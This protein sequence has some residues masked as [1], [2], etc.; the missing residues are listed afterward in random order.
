MKKINLF[1]LLTFISLICKAPDI[2]MFFIL[3]HNPLNPY[4]G[5]W[6]AICEHES[7]NDPMAY[8]R[9]ENAVGIVQIRP[10]LLKQYNIETRNNFQIQEMYDIKKSK[11][12]FMH[13]AK[14]NKTNE[15]I[16]RCWNGGPRG[17]SK[18]ITQS[19]YAEVKSIININQNGNRKTN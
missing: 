19:Y 2:K 8:N 3:T 16:A 9:K 5:I 15:K 13:F 17:M 1:I 11:Q 4:E 14:K 6:D 7:K 18:K 10:I 12:V